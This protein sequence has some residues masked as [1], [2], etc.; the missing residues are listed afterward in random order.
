MM[1]L[2]FSVEYAAMR[3]TVQNFQWIPDQIPRFAEVWKSK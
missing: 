1:P 2:F 3:D